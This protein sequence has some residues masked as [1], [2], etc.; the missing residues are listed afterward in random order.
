M[1]GTPLVPANKKTSTFPKEFFLS[2]IETS[3]IPYSSDDV[4]QQSVVFPDWFFGLHAH[5]RHCRLQSFTN[6]GVGVVIVLGFEV[7][8]VT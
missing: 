8:R 7:V 4:P 2:S 3:N 1:T 6:D 5:G